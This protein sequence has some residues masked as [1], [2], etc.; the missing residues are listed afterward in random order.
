MPTTSPRGPSSSQVHT[1]DLATALELPVE[2][3]EAAAVEAIALASG[4]AVEG[5]H[6]AEVLLALTGRRGL[7]AGFTVL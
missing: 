4:M 7:P 6:A 3:P 1:C 5:G 2:V